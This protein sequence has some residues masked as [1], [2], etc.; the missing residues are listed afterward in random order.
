MTQS[1]ELYVTEVYHEAY[2]LTGQLALANV[3]SEII[4]CANKYGVPFWVVGVL[5]PEAMDR[6]LRV[7]RQMFGS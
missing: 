2:G 6:A 7:R 1:T 4:T 5:S 3:R